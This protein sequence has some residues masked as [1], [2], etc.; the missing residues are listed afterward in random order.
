MVIGFKTPR[1]IRQ[2]CLRIAT[3]YLANF[4]AKAL[5]HPHSYLALVL[6]PTPTTRFPPSRILN[7]DETPIPFEYLDGKTCSMRRVK[8]VSRNTD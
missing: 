1:S 8:I 3:I 7:F 2:I 6:E 5:P 4:T